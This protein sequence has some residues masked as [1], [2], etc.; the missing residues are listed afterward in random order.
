MGTL[1]GKLVPARVPRIKIYNKINVG[2]G[3]SLYQLY[4][5]IKSSRNHVWEPNSD[6]SYINSLNVFIKKSN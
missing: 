4:I 6:R 1:C 2:S 5:C 3:L